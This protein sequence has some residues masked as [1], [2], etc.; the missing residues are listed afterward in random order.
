MA[1]DQA[2]QVT[3]TELTQK[4]IKIVANKLSAA[5]QKTV[6]RAA[7]YMEGEAKS[8][9]KVRTGT[10]RR[11][12]NAQFKGSTPNTF[13]NAYSKTTES[14]D[15]RVELEELE[16]VVGTNVVY[17][18]ELEARYPY[19]EPARRKTEAAFPDIVVE[20]VNKEIR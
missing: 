11:S 15:L 9:V 2:I 12:I 6:K 14:G 18:P 4:N 7:L 1:I 3:G 8:E 10:L 16:A 13:Y 17:G 20:D 5:L 19:L